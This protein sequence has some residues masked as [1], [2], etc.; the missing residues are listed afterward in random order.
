[1]EVSAR[2]RSPRSH[3]KSR[4]YVHRGGYAT[5]LEMNELHEPANPEIKK[6]LVKGADVF[7][8]Q[9][10]LSDFTT[11]T[12]FIIS[13]NSPFRTEKPRPQSLSLTRFMSGKLQSK[14]AYT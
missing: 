5:S 3:M 10:S 14:Q 7:N 8:I 13:E 4:R 12:C 11:F 1:M 6:E 2:P 9:G